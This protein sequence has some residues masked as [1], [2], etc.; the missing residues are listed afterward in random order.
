MNSIVEDIRGVWDSLVRP[1]GKKPQSVHEA[2]DQ[3]KK[4][5]FHTAAALTFTAGLSYIAGFLRDRIL[6]LKLGATTDLDLYY[7]A[8]VVPDLL[9]AVVVTS[10]IGTAFVP[11]FT[12]AWQRSREAASVYTY[13]ILFLLLLIVTGLILTVM[14]LAPYITD[15]IAS[16]YSDDQKQRYTTLMQIML[17]SP[18]LFTISN[19]FGGVLLSTRDFFF[20]GIAPVFYNLGIIVGIYFF[21]DTW[22]VY[23]LAIGTVFGAFLHMLSRLFIGGGRVDLFKNITKVSL[24]KNAEVKQTARLVLPKIFHILAWQILLLWFVRLALDMQEGGMT[25]YNYARNFQSVPVSLIGIAIALSAFTTL[26][27]QANTNDFKKF[28]KTYR[29]AAIRILLLT[30]I[31]ALALAAVAEPVIQ[32][33]FG[34]G[35]FDD[36]AIA[37]TALMLQVYALSIPFESLTH[38][39]ARAHYALKKTFI[40]S[41]ISVGVIAAIIVSSYVLAPY[42][43]LTVI[44]ITF[45]AGLVIQNVLL[46]VSYKLIS[47]RID[48]GGNR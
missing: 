5:L 30:G 32:L 10:T 9:V 22:G 43:G 18:L 16:D 39:L 37:Q 31:A 42:L 46:T 3:L 34:G 19:V 35:K 48:R 33:A 14:F 28:R 11:M 36:A 12:G 7:G 47:R 8:F 15:F 1:L 29:E 44:P 38:L 24:W 17:V 20:Y 23:G 45:F 40:P 6:A 25:I 4:M 13:N 2:G 21:F 27:Y 26:S 41:I